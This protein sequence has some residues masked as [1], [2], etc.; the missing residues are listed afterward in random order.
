MNI[1]IGNPHRFTNL[2]LLR[3]VLLIV[4]YF[5]VGKDSSIWFNA[6]L[7]V[8]GPVIIGERCSVQENSTFH[9]DGPDPVIIEDDVTIGHNVI[10]HGSKVGKR[11]LL[12][13]THLL[14]KI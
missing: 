13:K 9:L 3:Q 10:L 5:Q 1:L 7:R 2:F 8:N 11:R 6:V 12:E 4:H 14:L